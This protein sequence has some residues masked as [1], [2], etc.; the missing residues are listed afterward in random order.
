MNPFANTTTWYFV[1]LQGNTATSLMNVW[2]VPAGKTDSDPLDNDA[3]LHGTAAYTG[4]ATG[5]SDFSLCAYPKDK[6]NGTTY[7]DGV[8]L[9]DA[10]QSTASINA[11]YKNWFNPAPPYT[12]FNGGGV[13]PN[14]SNASNW[15]GGLPAAGAEVWF[16]P[17]A[18]QNT[19]Y[20]DSLTSNAGIRFLGAADT[21]SVNSSAYTLSGNSLTLTGPI[22]NDST[23]NQ[24]IA[25]TSGSPAAPAAA[26]ST[27]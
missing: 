22:N 13:T 23:N 27:P 3:I 11:D 15:S 1:V 7:F 2:M 8:A 26:R 5:G 10:A 19:P 12:Y 6:Y 9:Y 17:L 16:G 18:A 25:R 24:V 4:N 20:N 21:P 14:T